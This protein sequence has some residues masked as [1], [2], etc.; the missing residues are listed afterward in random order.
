MLS[1]NTATLSHFLSQTAQHL[2][3]CCCCAPH[4]YRRHYLFLFQTAFVKVCWKMMKICL[5]WSQ[6]FL[7]L[8]QKKLSQNDF[9]QPRQTDSWLKF[10]F[11]VEFEPCTSFCLTQEDTQTCMDTHKLTLHFFVEF[12]ETN[13]AFV[14][15]FFHSKQ[16]ELSSQWLWKIIATLSIVS[17][18]EKQVSTC[19]LYWKKKR[20]YKCKWGIM[21]LSHSQTKAALWASAHARHKT[22]PVPSQTKNQNRQ[23][24]HTD[25][26]DRGHRGVERT[27]DNRDDLWLKARHGPRTAGT[28]VIAEVK[29]PSGVF[30]VR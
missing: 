30:T 20:A 17:V 5:N 7:I 18:A 15:R 14:S 8:R 26:A 21:K 22:Q 12:V 3:V 23:D 9:S 29:S 24:G 13:P 1:L 19:V 16:L 10:I 27:R 2:R 25:E 4:K 28:W 11:T 6:C